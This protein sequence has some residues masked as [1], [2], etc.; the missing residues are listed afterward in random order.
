MISLSEVFKQLQTNE[1]NNI[2]VVNQQTKEIDPLQYSNVI[3]AI[4]AGLTQLHTRFLL[5]LGNLKIRLLPGQELYELSSRYIMTGKGKDPDKQF[6][7]TSPP[8]NGGVLKIQQVFDDTG[9]EL[10]L[11]NHSDSFSVQ[12]PTYDTLYVP[13]E[14]HDR[15]KVDTLKIVYRQNHKPISTEPGDVDP[16]YYGVSLS[17]SHLWALCLFVAGRMHYPIGLS[18]ATYSGN[19]FMALYEKECQ[20]LETTGLEI[21]QIAV[22]EGIWR[23]GFP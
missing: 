6:I 14:L 12:T 17:P 13:T 2:S 7:M 18:D 16:E 1:L 8:F 20:R 11:N 19:S 5:R 4:N 22:N 23:K 15:H 21:S 3:S 10:G 9:R